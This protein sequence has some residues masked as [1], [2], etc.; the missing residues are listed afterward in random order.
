MSDG[1]LNSIQIA[2]RTW[3]EWMLSMSLHLTLLVIFLIVL[4][5][6]LRTCS[7]R[8]RFLL[9]L[10]V[11]VRLVVP[12][13]LALPTGITWWISGWFP[14]ES[15]FV[16]AMVGD[17][18][19]TSAPS[20]VTANA[21]MLNQSTGEVASAEGDSNPHS[22]SA[23]I[24]WTLCLFMLWFGAVLAQLGLVVYGWFHVRA[25]LRSSL[26]IDDPVVLKTC[27]RAHERVGLRFMIEVRDCGRCT[28]P[29]VTGWLRPIILLPT[30]VQQTLK[31]AELEAVLVHELTHVK[32]CDSLWRFVEAVLCSLYFFHPGVWIACYFLER[33]REEACDELTVTALA[34][35]RRSYAEAIIKSSELV[36]YQPP[37]IALTM[38]GRSYP[39]QR[40]LARI[41]DP[42]LPQQRG[43]AWIRMAVVLSLGLLLLPSGLRNTQALSPERARIASLRQSIEEPASI[44]PAP[45]TSTPFPPVV[46]PDDLGNNSSASQIA[47]EDKALQQLTSTQF[48]ERLVAYKTLAVVGTVRSLEQLE[49]AF[50]TRS[51]I[52][53]D[54]AEQALNKVWQHIRTQ[55][56]DKSSSPRAYQSPLEK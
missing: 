54:A 37:H 27:R 16:T 49:K 19:S 33:N 25:W 11:L 31:P 36:G 9:W 32:R 12:P 40:R 46:T 28:T 51:G 10:L 30:V 42:K 53:Q 4:D 15:Q 29:L 41:L 5:R 8:L 2:T 43:N 23:S 50:L 13:D 17:W 22:L 52:E 1:L 6:L 34:G 21:G 26:P 44:K 56:G 24:D 7:A 18:V 47:L 48:D 45:A 20:D 55:T 38:L 35:K 39:V 3:C 14:S